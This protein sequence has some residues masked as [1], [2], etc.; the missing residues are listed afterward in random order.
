MSDTHNE[1][2]DFGRHKGTC[3]TRLPVSY[4]K[5]MVNISHSRVELAAAE[6]ARRGTTTPELD[7]S[8]HALDRASLHCRD[9][10][11][12]TRKLGGPGQDPEGIHSWL[13]RMAADA[14]KSGVRDNK[15]RLYYK[16][17]IFAFEDQ[18]ELVWPVLKTVMREKRPIRPPRIYDKD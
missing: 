9:L 11:K 14:L 1:I 10:W 18:E 13:C 8:G 7:V 3:Y 17:M 5:W 15:D 2:V 6:L 4:L 16:G 12:E